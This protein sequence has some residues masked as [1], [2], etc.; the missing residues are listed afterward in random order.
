MLETI[1]EFAAELLASSSEVVRVRDRHLS[2]YLELVQEAEP[3]LTGPDQRGWFERLAHEQ[4]NVREALASACD[5][6]DGERALMLA[7][8]IWRFWWSRGQ[9]DEASRW[10]ERAFAVGEGASDTAR[11]RG[12]FGAAHMAEARGDVVRARD[13]FER[14]ADLLRRIGETRWLIL[15]LAHLGGT[16]VEDPVRRESTYLEALELAEASGDVRGAAIAKG[17][18]GGHLFEKGEEQRA[19]SLAEE[20]LAGHRALADV[21]GIASS[22]SS[23]AEYALRRG[24][25]EAAAANLRESLE[26]SYS[27]RDTLSLSWTLALAASLVLAR[28]DPEAAARLCAADDALRT[29][30]GLEADP[31][32]GETMHAAG[33]VLGDRLDDICAEA[34][35]LDLESAVALA[36]GSLRGRSE[37]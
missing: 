4:D 24:D 1:R 33:E 37:P 16:Y 21:Y 6:A 19:V 10:Y 14:A 8:T 32:L 15:A 13:E 5:T 36:V 26:L 27:I 30:H 34:Q 2:F 22:L 35:S 7:G 31:L 9:V 3:Q 29:E 17:N 28:G 20:A 25:L 18:L 23:L 11:A 12:L